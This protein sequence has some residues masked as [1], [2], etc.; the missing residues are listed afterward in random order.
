MGL[1]KHTKLKN[2]LDTCA[3]MSKGSLLIDIGDNEVPLIKIARRN[4][5]LKIENRYGFTIE[6][7]FFLRFVILRFDN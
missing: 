3:V 2:K 7:H 1:E 6:T 4:K 5:P